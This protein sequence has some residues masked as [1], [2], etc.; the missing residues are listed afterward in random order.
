MSSSAVADQVVERVGVDAFDADLMQE[1]LGFF[2]RR[3]HQYWEFLKEIPKNGTKLLIGVIPGSTVTLRID[4]L[5]LDCPPLD[6]GRDYEDYQRL[7][8]L[9]SFGIKKIIY[10]KHDGFVDFC[11]DSTAGVNDPRIRVFSTGYFWSR[12][13]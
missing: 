8:G 4:L 9:V 1:V 5:T 6:E 13:P 10:D 12:S 3:S 2:L 11:F 7:A